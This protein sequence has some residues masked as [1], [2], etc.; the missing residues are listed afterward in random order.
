MT[1]NPTELNE[2]VTAAKSWA[3]EDPDHAT[4]AELR[5]LL[6]ALS[7][8]AAA[9]AAAAKELEERFAGTLEFGTAGLRAALGAG[10]RR[11]N[12]VVVRRTAAGIASFLQDTAGDR[13][14]PSAVIGFDA[15][16]NSRAF[17]LETAAVF[18]AAGIETFLLPCTLPTPVLAYA[19]RALDTD[20]GVMVTASHNPAEDNGYKVYLG[21]RTVKGPGKG[22][23]IV[24]PYD[25]EIA[26][27]INYSVPLKSIETAPEGWTDVSESIV[28]D[29]INAVDRLASRDRYPERDL[30]IVLTSLHGVGGETMK[31]VLKDAGFRKVIPVAAQAQPDPDFPTVAFPNPEEPGALDLALETA[32]E[33][34]ADLVIANDPD[35]DRV[36][37][38]AKNPADGQWRMLRGDEVGALLGRHL[39]LRIKSGHW[40]V[41]GEKT[42]SGVVYANSIVSSRLLARVAEEAGF[43]HVQT[44]TGFKWISRVPHLTYGYEEALGYCVAPG[45]V[46]D[47][48]GISAGLLMAELAAALKADGRTLFDELDDLAL[49]HGLHLTDQLSVRVDNLALPGTMMNRLRWQRPVTLGGSP[50][51]SA[52]DLSLGSADLPPTDGLKYLTADNTRVIIRPSG[53]EPKLKC[54]LEVIVPVDAAADLPAAREL[55]RAQLDAVLADVKTAL[56]L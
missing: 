24:A 46:R 54:Y 13:Y 2:L 18:S 49:Q 14:T 44:L 53:T 5:T 8:D 10:P 6:A 31:S 19:V 26:A 32:V 23:Q 55:G 4:A 21:G 30:K 45:L 34:N 33:H 16:H 29:Y 43:A 11:M 56:G 28:A 35:A 1:L 39:S 25:A 50:V 36:A 27:R 47:K 15:R 38:A 9:A 42:R 51:E 52:V 22:A 20:A 12:R 37:V 48:D 7:T 40:K 17:A 41:R 3:D